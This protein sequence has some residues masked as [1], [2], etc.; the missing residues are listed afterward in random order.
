MFSILKCVC[1]VRTWKRTRER[2][3]TR[4]VYVKSNG[5]RQAVNSDWHLTLA[6]TVNVRKLLFNSAVAFH[7][8]PHFWRVLPTFLAAS[9][10]VK[11]FKRKRKTTMNTQSI[12]IRRY[13]CKD[14][15]IFPVNY[16]ILFLSVFIMHTSVYTIHIICGV[17]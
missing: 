17:I 8:K 3:C 7:T 15:S 1:L 9:N 2:N 10:C 12:K 5:N 13:S 4:P 14:Y 6:E 16:C 11:Q